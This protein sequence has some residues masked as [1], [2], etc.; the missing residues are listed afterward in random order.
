MGMQPGLSGSPFT[1]QG[2][3]SFS[4]FPQIYTQP[5]PQILQALQYLPQQLQQL[6]Q[7]QWIQHQQVQQLLQTV[8]TQLQ[9]L[10]QIIQ[11]I[12]QQLP[13]LQ[14]QQFGGQSP[15]TLPQTLGS[16]YGVPFQPSAYGGLGQQ[17]QVM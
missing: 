1:H 16:G 10:Q 15:W 11:F 17:G 3:G 4:A 7:V 12:A 5:F 2:I 6:Q 9:Q 14:N 13:S 8:P